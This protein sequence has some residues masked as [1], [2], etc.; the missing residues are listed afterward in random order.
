MNLAQTDPVR[1]I[2]N[3]DNHEYFA[4]YTPPNAGFTHEPAPYYPGDLPPGALHMQ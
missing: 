1:A 3:A 2:M 4:E